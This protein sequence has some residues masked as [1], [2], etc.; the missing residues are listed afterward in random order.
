MKGNPSFIHLS[1]ANV[2]AAILFSFYQFY[3]ELSQLIGFGV[4][5]IVPTMLVFAII[6]WLVAGAL[7]AAIAIIYWFAGVRNNTLVAMLGFSINYFAISSLLTI[8][9]LP[10][11]LEVII[12]IFIALLVFV[13]M[14]WLAS[15]L[16][17]SRALSLILGIVFLS[18][19][20][21]VTPL[22]HIP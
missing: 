13:L 7:C 15:R 17:L 6:P 3:P 11:V 1:L 10:R 14:V 2:V 9:E 12:G 18:A 21:Y 19:S 16:S 22:S 5:F 8:W 20:L 4:M